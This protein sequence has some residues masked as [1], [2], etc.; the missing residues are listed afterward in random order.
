[1]LS[2]A[3]GPSSRKRARGA[4]LEVSRGSSV[5][6][7]SYRNVDERAAVLAYVWTH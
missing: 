1:M 2:L 7:V 4:R 3:R 6:N 5:A